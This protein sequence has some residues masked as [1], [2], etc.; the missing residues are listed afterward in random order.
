MP[1]RQDQL[2]SYQFSMQRV[3]AALVM[4][5]TDPAQS[6][7]RR[8][9][10]ATLASILIAA[11]IAA[12]F[13]V[14]GVFTGR[15]NEGWRK[16]FAV[17]IEKESG[18]HFVFQDDKLRPAL[19]F[20]SAVLAGG[21]GRPAVHTVAHA[22][23]V[24]VPRGVPFGL[25]GLPDSLPGAGELLGL[26]WSV[27]GVPA[28]DSQPPASVLALGDGEV[29]GGGHELPDGEAIVVEA[30]GRDG[31]D[32]Q[33]YLLWKRLLFPIDESSATAL[34]DKSRIRVP[35]AI[36]NVLPK[37]VKIESIV[38][39]GAGA[40]SNLP[41]YRIGQL[42]KRQ[43]LQ[44]SSSDAWAV[45]VKDGVIKLTQLQYEL[46]RKANLVTGLPEKQISRQE[47][48]SLRVVEDRVPSDLGDPRTPPTKVFPLPEQQVT[49][50]CAVSTKDAAIEVRVGAKISLAGR[51]RAAP[52]GDGKQVLVDYVFVEPGKGALV[53]TGYAT[54][55]ITDRGVAHA[56]PRADI[57][58]ML[59]Y[60]GK[61]PVKVPAE[62]AAL[63]PSGPALDPDKV[64]NSAVRS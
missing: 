9:A 1:S 46:A 35:A 53:T 61:A 24:G 45:V 28:A 56:L 42:L 22:S 27:C 39:P 55:L 62:L 59:G 57:A 15:G 58:T 63:V 54:L 18:A 34:Y 2:H 12:G 19:N 3:V 25:P 26:P 60:D 43:G 23:L 10:G 40:Q 38:V 52:G 64:R 32:L 47:F 50:L 4:R 20:A 5:E 8:A 7:F 6:P 41:G 36:V 11:I 14:Y 44:E 29:A 21:S 51:E 49:T 30:L 33:T 48:D 16:P 37:G 13:G 31:T 17:V